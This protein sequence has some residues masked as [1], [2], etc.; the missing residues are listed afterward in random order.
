M[1]HGVVRKTINQYHSCCFLSFLQ[2][3]V[4]NVMKASSVM[5]SSLPGGTYPVENM[6]VFP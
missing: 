5:V 2:N 1:K 3:V 6:T 4:E